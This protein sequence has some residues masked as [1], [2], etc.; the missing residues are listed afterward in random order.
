MPVTPGSVPGRE[1]SPGLWW[2]QAIAK[3]DRGDTKIAL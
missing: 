1:Q 3:R 2:F